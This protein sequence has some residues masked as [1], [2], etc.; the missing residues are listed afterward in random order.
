M[1]QSIPIQPTITWVGLEAAQNTTSTGI[2]VEITHVGF[3][4]AKYTPSKD[5]TSLV[6]E[7]L[8]PSISGGSKVT[9][10]QMQ[11]YC[12]VLASAGHPFWCGE[13][14]FYAGNVLFAVYSREESPLVYISDEVVTTASYAIQLAA[15]PPGSV[16]VNV[17]TGLASAA[18]LI[19]QH[20]AKTNPHPQ[21]EKVA[22]L[23]TSAT[24]NYDGTRL[25]SF[26]KVV[27]G[28][29][30]TTQ[31]VYNDDGT[32]KSVAYPWKGKTRTETYS[33]LNGVVTG[34]IATEV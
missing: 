34:Y 31:I 3:G 30:E 29:N 17:D 23:E 2:Q 4:T 10:T 11:I 26:T 7:V 6:A 14:G 12:D 22:Q 32:I 21:Y 5:Q 18:F 19:G 25:T 27:G 13:I 33:Y 1:P 16:T 20:E 15:L 28:N 24:F 8:R 9:A